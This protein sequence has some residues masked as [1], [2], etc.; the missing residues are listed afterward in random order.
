MEGTSSCGLPQMIMELFLS[1]RSCNSWHFPSA[2]LHVQPAFFPIKWPLIQSDGFFE[3]HFR[4]GVLYTSVDISIGVGSC[5]LPVLL[6]FNLTQYFLSKK[7]IREVFSHQVFA[8]HSVSNGIFPNYYP[9]LELPDFYVTHRPWTV[10]GQVIGS[11]LEE[12]KPSSEW[13]F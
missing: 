12:F 7:F 13:I 5:Y 3:C 10:M 4:D 11:I 2:L 8:F 1:L 6:F 9:L